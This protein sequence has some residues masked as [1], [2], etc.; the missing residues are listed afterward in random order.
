M[1]AVLTCRLSQAS[2]GCPMV[3]PKAEVAHRLGI[4]RTTL[5]E[6]LS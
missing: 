6:H 2:G 1:L 5:R 3:C 4:G